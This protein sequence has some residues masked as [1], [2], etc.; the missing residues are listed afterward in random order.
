VAAPETEL[1]L[2]VILL[3][4]AADAFTD[5]GADGADDPDPLVVAES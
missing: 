4:D 2:T 5:E 1:Q 3:D